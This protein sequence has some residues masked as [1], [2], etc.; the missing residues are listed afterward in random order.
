MT[1]SD[2]SGFNLA[3]LIDI[4]PCLLV[5]TAGFRR[6]AVAGSYLLELCYH[7]LSWRFR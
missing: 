1:C 6:N 4:V 3:L 7:L 2:M 5:E